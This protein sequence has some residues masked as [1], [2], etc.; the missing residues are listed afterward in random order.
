MK[1]LILLIIIFLSFTTCKKA[2]YKVE[3]SGK[4]LDDATG[5]PISGV[6]VYFLG[7]NSAFFSGGTSYSEKASVTTASDGSFKFKFNA[8]DNDAY[9]LLPEYDK[10]TY[11]L[12]KNGDKPIEVNVKKKL[13][14][15][16]ITQ[17]IYLKKYSILNIRFKQVTTDTIYA[18]GLSSI[19]SDVIF[20]TTNGNNQMFPTYMADFTVD[21]IY[22]GNES[23]SF[24]FGKILATSF[25]QY[26]TIYNITISKN[27]PT[28]FQINY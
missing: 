19:N 20:K 6:T 14:K 21:Y 24:Q 1:R 23:N 2:F 22:Y 11:F 28:Y 7:G 5:E 26:D 9:G 15:E 18:I 3:L 13:F 16:K 4:I 12:D 8:N 17:N 25:I 10:N 27:S